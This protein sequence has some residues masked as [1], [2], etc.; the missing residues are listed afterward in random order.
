MSV[1]DVLKGVVVGV[2]LINE[3]S[4]DAVITAL[5]LDNMA[6]W[7]MTYGA[8]MKVVLGVALVLLVVERMTTIRKNWRSGNEN[9]KE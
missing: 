5:Q 6:I 3:V 8:W 9:K 4:D 7:G 1:Y 2:P